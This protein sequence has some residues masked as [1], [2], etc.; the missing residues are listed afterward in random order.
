MLVNNMILYR[1]AFV[2]VLHK[3]NDPVY[4]AVKNY[5]EDNVMSSFLVVALLCV[6]TFLGIR[7]GHIKIRETRQKM[8]V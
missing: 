1:Y 2:G 4:F 6:A 7:N 8:Q 5:G 3:H